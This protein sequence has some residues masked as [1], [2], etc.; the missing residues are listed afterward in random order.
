MLDFNVFDGTQWLS[1]FANPQAYLSQDAWKPY[2]ADFLPFFSD[3]IRSEIEKWM[4]KTT[5]LY[6]RLV[7]KGALMGQG[8]G[9]EHALWFAD[10]PDDSKNRYF[11][12]LAY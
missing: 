11:L 6:D 9:L 10:G 8:F 12:N 5:S 1:G 4:Q 3:E 2:T 7:A